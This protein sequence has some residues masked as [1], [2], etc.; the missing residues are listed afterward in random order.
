MLAVGNQQFS[1]GKIPIETVVVNYQKPARPT[2]EST[3]T[4]MIGGQGLKTMLPMIPFD[5]NMEQV[6][7]E[8][9]SVEIV[10]AQSTRNSVCY[11]IAICNVCAVLWY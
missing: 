4:H 10:L 3:P 2:G 6:S 7:S 8:Y 5:S 1:V 9:A 11:L